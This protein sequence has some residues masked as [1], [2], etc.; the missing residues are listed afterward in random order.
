MYLISYPLTITKVTLLDIFI[1]KR[2]F[3]D[4]ITMSKANL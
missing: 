2:I 4:A 3:I 1:I